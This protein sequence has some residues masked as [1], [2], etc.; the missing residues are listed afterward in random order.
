MMTDYKI[1]QSLLIGNCFDFVER[2]GDEDLLEAAEQWLEIAEEVHAKNTNELPFEYAEQIIEYSKF[3]ISILKKFES[4]C[5]HEKGYMNSSIF[6]K[7]STNCKWVQ[8]G[9]NPLIRMNIEELSP[10][11]VKN[12]PSFYI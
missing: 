2:Y 10:E 5:S 12:N 9:T 3:T 11:P 4:L 8:D 6:K 7:A 1:V